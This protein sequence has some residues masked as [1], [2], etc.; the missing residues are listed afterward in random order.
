MP[1][2]R[3]WTFEAGALWAMDLRDTPP[4][5]A[6]AVARISEAQP[7]DVARLAWMMG[8]ARGEVERRFA[9]SSRCFVARVEDALAGYAW[10][11]RGSERIGELERSLR[12][13]PGE[14][15]I[16]DCATL[17]PYRRQ[18]VYTALLGVM[19]ATLRGEGAGRV[20]IGASLANRPSLRGFARAGFQPTLTVYYLRL[21]QSAY[22]WTT[23]ARGASPT[24]YADA[25]WAL[26]DER[27]RTR[28]EVAH[29]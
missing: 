28:E 21:G 14:A 9:A 6:P 5:R 8:V 29:G 1:S 12:M 11:S 24:L 26:V 27:A 7:G 3:L 20:W 2:H 10:V 22:T 15:Y 25:R 18:G 23:R 17:P 16:W 19:V 4:A 13:K